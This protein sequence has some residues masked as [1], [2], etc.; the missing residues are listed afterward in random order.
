MKVLSVASEV[1]PLIKTGGLADVAGAL[2]AALEPFDISVT[3][4]VPGYRQVMQQLKKATELYRF[5]DL[6]G[7]PAR[8]LSASRH[9]LDLIVLDCPILFDRD[10]G[11]Y[12]DDTGQ[13]WPDN[14]RRFAAFSFAAAECAQGRAGDYRADLIHVHD[15]QAAMTPAY[16]R[17]AMTDPLPSVITIHNI[18]FQGQFAA[19][20][21]GELRMP[22]NA[23]NM[24][25]IEY[26]GG[27]GFLKAG[28]QAASAITTVSPTYAQEIRQ[29]EF[30]MGLEGLINARAADVYGI[31]NGIDTE[32]WNPR[33]D[34]HLRCTYKPSSLKRRRENRV[35]VEERFGIDHDDGLLLCVVSRLSWQKGLDILADAL[36]GIVALGCKLVVLGSGDNQIEQAFVAATERHP[37]RIGIVTGYDEPLSHLMQGGADALLVPSRFEP[38]GL[39]QL[40]GLRYGCIPIVARTGGLSD[41]VIDHNHAAAISGVATGFQFSPLTPEALIHA[42][43]RAITTFRD[44]K[45]WSS[46]QRRGMRSDVSWARSAEGYARLF[47]SLLQDRT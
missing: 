12:G 31:V 33:T 46:M 13:D 10:G 15:W 47:Q 39:T 45:V 17:Y 34:P 24:D 14:W 26:Y 2:P 21:F 37:G 6:F 44:D 11:P 8:L 29:P 20:V 35:A 1:F 18:A 4:F 40:Y 41:T 43:R 36:D 5:S 42:V 27:V 22:P 7:V 16:L 28:L 19:S 23:M 30:G 25:G 32:V 9:G 3:T 38:C